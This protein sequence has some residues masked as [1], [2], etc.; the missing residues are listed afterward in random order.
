MGLFIGDDYPHE[1]LDPADMS[2]YR[3]ESGKPFCMNGGHYLG[4][5]EFEL[6]ERDLA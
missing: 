2:D 1:V 5:D 4:L 6:D 3:A